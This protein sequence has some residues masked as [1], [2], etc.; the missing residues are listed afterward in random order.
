MVVYFHMFSS[1]ITFVTGNPDKLKWLQMFTDLP[2]DYQPLDLHEIQ[3]LDV[4]KVVEH[5]AKD[6]Y[7]IV[8]KPVLI[9]D[10]SLLFNA[11]GK[12][13]GPLIKWFLN[14]LG[15]EGLC[16][17]LDGFKDRSAEAIVLFG[18]YDGKTFKTFKG[19]TAGIITDK[20]RG[21][22]GF[23]WDSIFIPVGYDVTWAEMSDK[24]IIKTSIRKRALKKL[25]KYLKDR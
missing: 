14:E 4:A 6:A 9:E 20:P 5:K 10:T 23:G 15:N 11:L 19:K 12:L 17:L 13:P 1:P 22:N 7:K 24:G 8:K 18:L 21:G 2:L 3:S 25:E 16:K